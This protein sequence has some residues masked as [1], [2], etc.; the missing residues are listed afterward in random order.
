M[1]EHAIDI[2]TYQLEALGDGYERGFAALKS[3]FEGMSIEEF[4]ASR[5]A[6][7]FILRWMRDLKLFDRRLSALFRRKKQPPVADGFTAAVAVCLEQFLSA[8]GLSG[9]VRSEET[10]IPK[11]GATRPDVSVRNRKDELI[12]TIECK[13]N[14]GWARSTWKASHE[15]RS[16]N[17]QI[18]FPDCTAYLCV[19]TQRNWDS[20]ELEQSEFYER[21]WFCLSNSD[22]LTLA[23]EIPDECIL[24]PI[25]PMFV[26][27][28]RK[29]NEK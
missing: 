16:S 18:L 12:A 2:I 20:S 15:S 4:T 7:R 29:L 10:T 28:L 8:H 26:E 11:K 19:M 24:T 23:P 27:L 6:T 17:L 21:E 22:V 25:E 9:C 1:A 3:E 13:T 5:P 14:L